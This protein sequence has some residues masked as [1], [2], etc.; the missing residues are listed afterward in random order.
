MAYNEQLT[1]RVRKLLAHLPDV[2]E[3]KMFGS[4]GFMVNG[5]LCLGVGDHADHNMMVRVG[6]EKYQ[7]ALQRPGAA[8]AIMRGRERPGYVFL[9]SSAVATQQDLEY[10]VEL[11]LAYNKSL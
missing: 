3:R 4:I 11:A 7:E 6:P 10:W 2:Q 1:E 9:L 8:P 5:K